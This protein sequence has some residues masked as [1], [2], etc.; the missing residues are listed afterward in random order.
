MEFLFTWAVMVAGMAIGAV[1]GWTSAQREKWFYCPLCG[2]H[3]H[4]VASGEV[5]HVTCH[6]A[7]ERLAG[8]ALATAIRSGE[9]VRD[10]AGTVWSTKTSA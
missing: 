1:I 10:G 7:S 8:E 3:G 2:E 9:T 4:L 6:K 5:S